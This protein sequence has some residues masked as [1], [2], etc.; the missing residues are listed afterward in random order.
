MFFPVTRT[1]SSWIWD[2]TFS[3]VC[4]TRATI[5]LP[6]SLEIPCWMAIDLADEPAG[7]GLHLPVL[8]GLEGDPA[9]H[10]L[11]LEDVDDR[12]Q[13]EVVVGQHLDAVLVL[14]DLG[15]RSP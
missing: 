6:F 3:F 10:E 7:G 15:L 1:C 4:L 2:W 11:R 5:S 12:L 14:R 13:A 8:E 9:L